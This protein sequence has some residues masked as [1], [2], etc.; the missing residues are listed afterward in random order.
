MN[1]QISLFIDNEMDMDEKISFIKTV[2]KDE[3][4]ADDVLDLLTNTINNVLV[5]ILVKIDKM[6]K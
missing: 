6:G 1:D 2:R 5:T 3:G 4:F